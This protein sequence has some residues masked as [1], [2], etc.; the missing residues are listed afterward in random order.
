LP[1][2]FLRP[3]SIGPAIAQPCKMYGPQGSCPISTLYARMMQ[4]TGGKSIWYAPNRGN[5][6]VDE[7]P[8]DLAANILLQHVH[9]GTRGVVHA[10]SS[11]YI[12]KTLQW[13]LEQPFKYLPAHWISRMATPVF[14]GDKRVEQSKEAKFYRIGSRAWEFRA[15]SSHHLGSLGGPLKFGLSDHDTDRFAE[16]RIRSIFYEN[17]GREKYHMQKEGGIKQRT[18]GSAKL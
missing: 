13:I 5:N 18:L 7:I 4:P 6:V 10:S 12:P 8:V 1:L 9:S 3:T 16:L 15:P 11:Y 17:F 14:V 2:L